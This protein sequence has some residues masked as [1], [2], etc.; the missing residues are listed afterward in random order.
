[1]LALQLKWM[2]PN[3]PIAVRFVGADGGGVES[4]LGVHAL[5]HKIKNKMIPAKKYL[6]EQ[7]NVLFIVALTSLMN[8]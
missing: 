3:D 4:P 8:F 2:F 1:V 6:F 5:I 7:K